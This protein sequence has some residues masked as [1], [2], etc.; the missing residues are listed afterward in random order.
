MNVTKLF[1]GVLPSNRPD[2]IPSNGVIIPSY[3]P[4]V[5]IWQQLVMAFLP[6]LRAG[7]NVPEHF[8]CAPSPRTQLSSRL[9][10]AAS[11][12][13]PKEI[14]DRAL[15]SP[16]AQALAYPLLHLHLARSAGAELI[17]GG[18]SRLNFTGREGFKAS[19]LC[20]RPEQQ[21]FSPPG[22]MFRNMLPDASFVRHRLAAWRRVSE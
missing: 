22:D 3:C 12:V 7:S 19:M 2:F 13:Q 8:R 17:C 4:D 10:C 6:H 5:N 16:L 1:G 15:S 11:A 18:A 14:I 21:G 20:L 9:G